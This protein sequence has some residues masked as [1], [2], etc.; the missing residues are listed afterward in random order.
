VPASTDPGVWQL[1]PSC[2]A[3]GGLFLH[4]RNVT[5]FGIENAPDFIASPPPALTSNR[6][7]NGLNEVKR[8]G[9]KTSTDRPQDRTDVAR[10][11]AASSPGY[12]MN[13][14][15]RQV[16]AE[17]GRSIAHNARAFALINMAISDSFVASFAT[18]YHY[19]FWRPET[20]IHGADLDGNRKTESD[21]AWEPLIVAPC[22]PGYGSNHA[23]GSYGGAE[24]LRRLYGA[25]GHCITISNPA[26]PGLVFQYSEFKQITA[27]IDDARIYGG[28]HFRFDQEAGARL[29]RDVATAVWQG[30]LR[31]EHQD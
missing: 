27:D 24:V 21:L 15:A 11:Y 18:K 28:I 26:L 1:T 20:A 2:V 10:F 25:G 30:N 16:S 12:V 29:G 22:F 6:Y 17:Q 31:R 4:W 23:S 3:G 14:A 13:L 8:V 7:A 9:S 5:P 19:N